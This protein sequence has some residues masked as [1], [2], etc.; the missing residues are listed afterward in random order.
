MRLKVNERG[1]LYWKRGRLIWDDYIAHTQRA[2]A[3]GV[4]DI[5]RAFAD[6]R[7]S[8][9]VSIPG[10]SPEDYRVSLQ[11]LTEVGVLL[12]DSS[13]AAQREE[14]LH[15]WDKWG[16]AAQF[17][18][19]AT[20][21]R[22]STRFTT[23]ADDS[24][25]LVDKAIVDPPPSPFKNHDGVSR[26]TLSRP[27]L[28]HE[29]SSSSF[30]AVLLR[31]RTQRGFDRD[32]ALSR[33]VVGTL[34]YLVAGATHVVETPHTGTV[35]QRTSPSGG[36]RHPTEVYPVVRNVEGIQPGVY[37]YSV[38]DHALE[39]LATELSDVEVLRAAGDQRY[40]CDAA[41]ILL[42][43]AVLDR[44]MWKYDIGRAYRVIFL[45]AG[46]LDQTLYLTASWLEIGALF[47]AAVRDES[48]EQIVRLDPT[49][50]IVVGMGA[51]GPIADGG[52]ARQAAAFTGTG[53][54][55]P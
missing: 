9:D 55:M 30:P 29:A 19:F 52:A 25:R 7:E 10:L 23:A 26:I 6:W 47:S 45:D 35:I 34:L 33:D 18:H 13:A 5:L 11:E 50:E 4:E 12:D 41:L 20:R 48:I 31:R 38:Q 15:P 21:T 16:I 54:V 32:T 53:D 3:P 42:Y 14:R 40:F 17:Y 24:Q 51:V 43:T 2:L 27:N 36:S 37:H 8:E 28:E 44:V 1:V 39:L 49:R 46:H 22:A